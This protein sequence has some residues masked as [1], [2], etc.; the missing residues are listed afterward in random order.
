[1]VPFVVREGE[2]RS[3]KRA[4]GMTIAMTTRT[5]AYARCLLLGAVFVLGA[6]GA[7]YAEDTKEE[8]SLDHH[9]IVG[10]GGATELELRERSFHAA[11]NVMVEWEAIENW[12]E[13]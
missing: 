2:R 7:A 6:E 13:P 12:L 3:K 4:D 10:I 11:G 8:E 1:M 5:R 9:V